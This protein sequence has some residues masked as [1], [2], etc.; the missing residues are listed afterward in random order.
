M[1]KAADGGATAAVPLAALAALEGLAAAQEAPRIII[2]F[3]LARRLIA[4]AGA[5]F[6]VQHGL[7]FA[8]VEAFNAFAYA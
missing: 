8:G 5:S 4:I 6:G 3:L 2:P 7:G 1:R